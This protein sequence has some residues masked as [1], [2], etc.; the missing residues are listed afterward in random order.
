[1]G[2]HYSIYFAKARLHEASGIGEWEL[3]MHKEYGKDCPSKYS[4][5]DDINRIYHYDEHEC[6]RGMDVEFVGDGDPEVQKF[7]K[8]R[9]KNLKKDISY[10]EKHIHKFKEKEHGKKV[11]ISSKNSQH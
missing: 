7:I 1:M 2:R 11:S 4:V 3:V 5:I 6:Y 9:I 10:L 8:S